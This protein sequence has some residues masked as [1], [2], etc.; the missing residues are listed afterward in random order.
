MLDVHTAPEASARLP[1]PHTLPAAP[2]PTA[3]SPRASAHGAIYN[4]AGTLLPVLEA[5]RA[6]DAATLRDAMTR[7]FGADDARG[8]W[9]WKDAL[10]GGRGRGRAVHPPPRPGHAPPRRR[11][12]GRTRRH[13]QDAGGR[14]RAGAL[15]HQALRRAGSLAAV[16]DAPAARLRGVAGSRCPAGRHRAGAVG[17]H[18]HAGGDGGMRARKPGARE[19]APERDRGRPPRAPVPA[20]PGRRGHRRE[21]RERC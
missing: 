5:G 8:A 11:R 13:A 19:P 16:L 20:L 12:S 2:G 15:P 14:G 7:A 18:G 9:V 4:A 6:L 17:G 21:R 3:P 1:V 10:R